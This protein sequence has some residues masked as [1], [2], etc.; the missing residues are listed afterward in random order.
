MRL[1]P[2]PE[3]ELSEWSGWSTCY[4]TCYYALSVRNRDVIRPAIPDTP[5]SSVKRCPHLY[6][7]RFCTM[8]SCQEGSTDAVDLPSHSSHPKSSVRLILEKKLLHKARFEHGSEEFRSSVHV[9]TKSL[10]D[11]QKRNQPDRDHGKRNYYGQLTQTLEA[12]QQQQNRDTTT[13]SFRGDNLAEAGQLTSNPNVDETTTSAELHSLTIDLP[14]RLKPARERMAGD[15]KMTWKLKDGEGDSGTTESTFGDVLR[16]L[17]TAAEYRIPLDDMRIRKVLRR[18]KKLMRALIE[19]YRLRT[20]TSAPTTPTTITTEEKSEYLTTTQV[21]GDV[22]VESTTIGG[23]PST[24]EGISATT[25]ELTDAVEHSNSQPEYPQST[26]SSSAAVEEFPSNTA[27]MTQ[28]SESAASETSSAFI[29]SLEQ[30]ESVENTTGSTSEQLT[31]GVSVDVDRG[32]ERHMNA[33][34]DDEGSYVTST[35]T[36]EEHQAN[37]ADVTIEEA[38]IPKISSNAS[39]EEVKQFDTSDTSPSS[40]EVSTSVTLPTAVVETTNATTPAS[41]T[42]TQ[43]PYWPKKGYVPNTRKHASEITSKLYM[44]QEIIQ[45]LSDDP[46]RRPS[47]LNLDCEFVYGPFLCVLNYLSRV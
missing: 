45:A 15:R 33:S 6:E 10:T 8:P 16:E 11:Q 46:I 12:L 43:L 7:T 17:E 25:N 41:T 42:T 32:G 28:T 21:E 13:K 4:G 1:S 9:S 47:I 22:K 20:T 19:A 23:L 18:N 34:T 24:S 26:T 37:T 39:D 40:T 35:V 3:C 38:D 27:T 29:V 31:T 30:Q 2:H 44:T 14:K 36:P 5:Q